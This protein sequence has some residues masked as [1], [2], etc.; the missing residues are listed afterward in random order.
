MVAKQSGLAKPLHY[1]VNL[2]PK[3]ELPGP[4]LVLSHL[5]KITPVHSVTLSLIYFILP[6]IY[7]TVRSS[8]KG[9]IVLSVI[10]FMYYGCL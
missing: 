5:H 2:S 6:L 4:F 10:Y 1:E 7:E 3:E 8:L 9:A